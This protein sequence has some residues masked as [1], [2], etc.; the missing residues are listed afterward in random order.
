MAVFNSALIT[1]KTL[2]TALTER[3]LPGSGAALTTKINADLD[4]NG[5]LTQAGLPANSIELE[6]V[7][8][9]AIEYAQ[10][11]IIGYDTFTGAAPTRGVN[12]EPTIGIR[13]TSVSSEGVPTGITD[14][15]FGAGAVWTSIYSST[16]QPYTGPEEVPIFNS[17]F[18][19]N[20]LFTPSRRGEMRIHGTVT[21]STVD[22]TTAVVWMASNPGSASSWVRLN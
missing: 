21:G 17:A 18:S 5:K 6:T 20:G 2:D 15:F 11:L 3:G 7:I 10:P 4:L 13:A 14:I 16:N 12:D 8:Y 19:P 9:E 1:E 22:P